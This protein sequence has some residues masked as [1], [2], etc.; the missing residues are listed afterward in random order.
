M[1]HTFLSLISLGA[2][3]FGC[4]T[5]SAP[6][7]TP[8]EQAEIIPKSTTPIHDT[9]SIF[10]DDLTPGAETL[11]VRK[12][13]DKR[14]ATIEELQTKLAWIEKDRTAWQIS[15][16]NASRGWTNC[17]IE[18][19]RCVEDLAKRPLPGKRCPVCPTLPPVFPCERGFN[20]GGF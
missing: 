5:Y 17:L 12:L 6:I 11:L 20:N 1:K 18:R 13:I 10:G 3:V 8:A 7:L 4:E 9:E 19:D 15:Q 16:E 2:F 14:N